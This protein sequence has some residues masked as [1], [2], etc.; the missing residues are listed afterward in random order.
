MFSSHC[1]GIDLIYVINHERHSNSFISW[2]LFPV[3][4]F[5]KCNYSRHVVDQ[6]LNMTFINI[7]MYTFIPLKWNQTSVNPIVSL[8][9][10]VCG[11]KTWSLNMFKNFISLIRLLFFFFFAILN[12]YKF[13]HVNVLKLMALYM[14]C[15]LLKT[16]RWPNV[17]NIIVI[18]SLV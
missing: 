13:C 5:H 4:E 15:L 3:L 2:Y 8:I 7:G 14:F 9:G 12:S 10:G 18:W 6:I 11:G 17:V 1:F 16:K